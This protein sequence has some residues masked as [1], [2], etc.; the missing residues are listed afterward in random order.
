MGKTAKQKEQ[1]LAHPPLVIDLKEATR[2]LR[3]KEEWQSAGRAATTLMKT[4][5]RRATLMAL[6]KGAILTRHR[7][8]GAV[9]LQVLSGRIRLGT[10]ASQVEV[11]EGSLV[12]LHPRVSHD[13][14]A[15][16]ESELLL[17]VVKEAGEA[18][19]VEAIQL[20]IPQPLKQ[21]HDELHVGLAE[22][23]NAGGAVGAAAKAVAELMHPHF[24]KEEM[25]A[26]PPL[27]LLPLLAEH[28]VQ[29]EMRG[30]PAMTDRLERELPEMLEEH[31]AI[32]SALAGLVEAATNEKKPEYARFA[33]KLMLH[34]HAEEAVSYPTARLI[35]RYVRE[36]LEA[37]P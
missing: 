35:G 5:Y 1:E 6:R 4:P 13:V 23:I 34:A 15:I 18:P 36:H 24:V 9:L 37:Q 21:E 11:G 7:T 10:D 12:S 20:E 2:R 27:G 14:E 29:P 32:V 31:R 25:F 17:L 3:K 22:A 16:E 28:G 33:E 19:Q 30:V 8:R 26:L